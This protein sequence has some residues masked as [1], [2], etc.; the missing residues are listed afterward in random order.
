MR[1]NLSVVISAYNEEQRIEE[2]FH[3]LKHYFSHVQYSYEIIFVNDGSSDNTK[4]KIES[5][6]KNLTLKIKNLKLISYQPNKG[7]GYGI[8]QGVMAAKGQYIL[9]SDVDLSTPI[10][11]TEKLFKFIKKYPI[12]I[13]SRYLKKG[14]VKVAQPLTRRIISRLGNSLIKLMLGLFYQDTQCGFKLLDA[15]SAK[16]IFSRATISRWGFDI[17]MLAIAKILGCRVKETAVDWYNDPR[18]QVRASRAVI[19][20][21]RE[22]LKIRANIKKGIYQHENLGK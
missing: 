16:D 18:S 8:R 1:I 12:V 13:G 6:N 19:N 5:L 4:L 14:S 11:E 3:K 22:V 7:K 21:F 2:C 17:E 10:K 9:F 20:T 15:R